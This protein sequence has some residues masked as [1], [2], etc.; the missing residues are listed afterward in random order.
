M[1]GHEKFEEPLL[2]AIEFSWVHKLV[3]DPLMA[4][5]DDLDLGPHSVGS[6]SLLWTIHVTNPLHIAPFQLFDH[7]QQ[8][9]CMLQ[10]LA[11]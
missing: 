6:P 11:V 2:I 9:G 5:D 1:H 8:V 10:H 4:V 3:V 7:L